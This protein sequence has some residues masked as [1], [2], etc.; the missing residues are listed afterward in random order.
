M[1]YTTEEILRQEAEL[2]FP[3]FTHKDAHDLGETIFALYPEFTRGMTLTEGL[4]VRILMDG[5]LVY[6]VLG[7]DK[8]EDVW[9][10]RK[11]NTVA[12]TGHASLYVWAA[13]EESGKY[14]ELHGDERYVVCG[15]GFPLTVGGVLRGSICVSGL[16]H[17]DDHRLLVEGVRKFLADRKSAGAV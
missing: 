8:N 16:E 4:G 7:D 10:R 1:N 11:E 5:L 14:A 9:L 3:A 12:L 13:N 17:R 15:G 2:V 6:Q